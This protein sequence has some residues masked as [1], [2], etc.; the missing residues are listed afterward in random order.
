[1]LLNAG[2]LDVTGGLPSTNVHRLLTIVDPLTGRSR[3]IVGDDQGIF[4][5]VDINGKVDN[6]IGTQGSATFSRSGNLQ[7]SQFYYGASQPSSLAAQAAM[8][9]A[10]GNGVHSAI[11][12]SAPDV[13]QTG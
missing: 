11:A 13:L 4:T 9:L 7:I 12:A 8:A 5:G 2:A 3:L 10:Y 6:G 1:K